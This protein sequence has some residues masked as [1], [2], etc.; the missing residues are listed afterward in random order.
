MIWFWVHCTRNW[1]ILIIIAVSMDDFAT[2][3][4]GHSFPKLSCFFLANGWGNR[5][6]DFKVHGHL[7]GE[8]SLPPSGPWKS[9][10]IWWIVRMRRAH[11]SAH[12]MATGKHWQSLLLLRNVPLLGGVS[13]TFPLHPAMPRAWHSGWVD[14][15]EFGQ[16]QGNFY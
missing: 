16:F 14:D 6:A 1:V 4:S 2:K 7:E 12:T 13:S 10:R 5:T 11:T 15:K 3:K 8:K 9:L